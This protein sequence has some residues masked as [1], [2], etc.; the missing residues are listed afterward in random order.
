MAGRKSSMFRKSAD[1]ALIGEVNY[2]LRFCPTYVCNLPPG[3]PGTFAL[4][5]A[6]RSAEPTTAVG[7]SAMGVLPYAELQSCWAIGESCSASSCA[8][9]PCV[10]HDAARALSSEITS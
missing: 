7:P 6:Q 5:A 4:F 10:S 1:R 9:A 2:S 8:H 3:G